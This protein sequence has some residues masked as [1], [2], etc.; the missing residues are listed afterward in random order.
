[1]A[2]KSDRWS[3]SSSIASENIEIT[4]QG[5]QISS[6]FNFKFYLLVRIW[7][8]KIPSTLEN[9]MSDRAKNI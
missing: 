8:L 3:I 9:V 7:H 5:K 6:N 2:M 1:M 4:V